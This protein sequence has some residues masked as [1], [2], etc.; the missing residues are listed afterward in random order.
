MICIEAIRELYKEDHDFSKIWRDTL[1]HVYTKDYVIQQ[2]FLFKNFRLCI[3]DKC[4]RLK[5]ITDLHIGG[6]A[7]RIGRDKTVAAVE[8]R[9]YWPHHR[10]DIIKFIQR[11]KL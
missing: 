7:A 6:L 2:D 8:A 3:P 10:R 9:F 11:C 5:I 4:L 1:H